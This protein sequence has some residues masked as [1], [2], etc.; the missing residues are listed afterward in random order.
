MNSEA[1]RKIDSLN[2]WNPKKEATALDYIENYKDLD[3]KKVTRNSIYMADLGENLG[4][5]VSKHRPVLV[6]SNNKFNSKG[7]P[8]VI[9]IPLT[10]DLVRYRANVNKPRYSSHYFLFKE[11]YD[12]LDDDSSLQIE[13]MKCI[14]K[15]RLGRYVGNIDPFDYSNINM[16]IKNFLQL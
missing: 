3:T 16:K 9:I 4:R 12:F 15:A 5:E 2:D 13:Q 10:K 14:S 7:Q 1:Q 6:I 8:T 11:K